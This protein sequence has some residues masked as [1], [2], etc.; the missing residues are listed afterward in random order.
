M[1][2]WEKMQLLAFLGFCHS[3]SLVVVTEYAKRVHKLNSTGQAFGPL[4]LSTVSMP[5][6]LS[7]ALHLAEIDLGPAHWWEVVFAILLTA[8]TSAAV[9]MFLYELGKRTW[10]NVVG[11]VQKR[12]DNLGG[13]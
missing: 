1:T 8:I 4:V 3:A 2:I 7:R 9:S 12:I 10:G 13:K 6:A 11:A 5:F